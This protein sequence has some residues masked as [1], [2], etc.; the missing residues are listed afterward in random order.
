MSGKTTLKYNATSSTNV[1]FQTE[2][3]FLKI[4]K[5]FIRW[6]PFVK[7]DLT[8]GLAAWA[9]GMGSDHFKERTFKKCERAGGLCPFGA[10]K[11]FARCPYHVYLKTKKEKSYFVGRESDSHTR[12]HVDT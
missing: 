5:F 1:L 10:M 3:C 4:I 9:W 6:T 2:F 8:S 12:T 7:G 11:T